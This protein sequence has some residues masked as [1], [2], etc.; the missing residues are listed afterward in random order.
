ML[1]SSPTSVELTEFIQSWEEESWEEGRHWVGWTDV[2]FLLFSPPHPLV[3]LLWSFLAPFELPT[4]G[5]YLKVMVNCELSK[6]CL[7]VPCPLEY[8]VTEL[9][10][11]LPT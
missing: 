10:V 7:L 6:S 1:C 4:L 8:S 11:S 9:R 2:P 5:L 3:M